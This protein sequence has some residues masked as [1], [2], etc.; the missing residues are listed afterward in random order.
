MADLS[1]EQSTSPTEADVPREHNTSPMPGV[2]RN[3]DPAL[4]VV[5]EHHHEHLHHDAN[6]E[7]GHNEFDHPAYTT[8]TT[9]EPH[10]IPRADRNEDAL[11]R[12]RH[13]PAEHD[14]EKTGGLEYE[15]KQGSLSKGRNSSD[16][17]I[18]EEP[19]RHF[20][21][22]FYRKYRVFFHVFIGLLFTG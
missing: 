18:E 6:A 15:E 9:D 20:F 3:P 12:R 8:G 17:E 10:V 13:A 19:R 11:H 2:A 21:A 14:I 4:D 7:K 22:R 16:P 5:K 1:R